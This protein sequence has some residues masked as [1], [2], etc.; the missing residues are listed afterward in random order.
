MNGPA[1]LEVNKI[2]RNGVEIVSG[3]GPAPKIREVA[4]EVTLV[5]GR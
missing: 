1:R 3:A 2:P 5:I 4:V